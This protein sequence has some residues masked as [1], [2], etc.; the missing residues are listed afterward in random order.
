MRNGQTLESNLVPLQALHSSP[1]HR[2]V[3]SVLASNIVLVELDGDVDVLED[4][5]DRVGDLR[6]DT[7]SGDEG[8]LE[9]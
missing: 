3:S 2:V 5:L 1:E 7:I 6:S 8:D 9:E 4:L